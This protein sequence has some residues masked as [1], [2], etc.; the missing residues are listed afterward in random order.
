MA[1]TI[2]GSGSITGISAGGLPDGSVTAA[3]IESSLDLSGKTVTLPSGTGGKVLQVVSATKTDTFSTSSLTF[4]D[5]PDLSVTLTPS[6]STNKFLVMANVKL[7][8]NA[9]YGYF[10]IERDGLPISEAD[11]AGTRPLVH[12]V[13]TFA[14][15]GEDYELASASVQFLET[16]G[17]TS[18][19]TFNVA[20]MNYSGSYLTYV[21][22]SAIDRDNT[23]YEPRSI[24][25]ITVMEI[26][27]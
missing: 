23:T 8:H 21:N 12:G 20:V 22:R 11:T 14:N 19:T 27:P 25:S 2:N 4:V 5:V 10:R 13:G 3:D 18:S 7:G 9:Y 24:S 16:A 26:A 1:I 6:S 17:S 15:G